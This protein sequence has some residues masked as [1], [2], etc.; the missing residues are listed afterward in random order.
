MKKSIEALF[1]FLMVILFAGALLPIIYVLF[2][3]VISLE[4]VSL[5]SQSISD[6]TRQLNLFRNTMVIAVGASL[7]SLILGAPL[8]FVLSRFSFAARSLFLLICPVPL[9]IPAYVH[10][11]CWM[12]LLGNHGFVSR[13]IQTAGISSADLYTPLGA[14]V[15]MALS[16]YPLVT[17]MSYVGFNQIDPDL[18]DAARLQTGA[19]K[20][21]WGITANIA[22]PAILTGALFSCIFALSNFGVPSMLRQQVYSQEVFYQFSN[23]HEM[24]KAALYSLPIL[25]LSLIAL[26]GIRRLEKGHRF[27]ISTATR[28]GNRLP[29]RRGSLLVIGLL[30]LLHLLSVGL[31]ISVLFE[32]AG[33]WDNYVA[34]L[35]NA[36]HDILLSFWSSVVSATLILATGGILALM[37][38]NG[39]R[40]AK[41]WLERACV[42][43]F[44]FPAAAAGIG[45]IGIWNRGGPFQWVYSSLFILLIAFFCRYVSFA[46]KPV[47]TAANYIDPSLDESA[48]LTGVS[49]RR[50]LLRVLAP[51]GGK[52]LIVAWFLVYL[53]SMI[54]LDT[55]ILVHPPGQA[56]L[57]VRI[58][59]LL[60]FGRQEWV[61]A[62]C[63]VLTGLT[64]IPYMIIM[65]WGSKKKNAISGM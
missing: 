56:T 32:M 2:R 65:L 49:W 46:F 42:L 29:L 13:L 12:H 25:L 50:R 9:L 41:G 33:D 35:S 39:P 31:P 58:F 36:R 44:A 11:I 15:I 55:V 7:L 40:R 14:I 54:D 59:N 16:Y 17:L 22:A 47:L 48:R 61:G 30:L 52:G 37:A 63:L 28:K 43:S 21:L 5:V 53:F 57:P 45:L 8:A 64:I 18:E 19:W 3:S 10:T 20:T 38:W 6:W 34:S 62:L 1:S 4:N 51:L 60:H 23:L 26:F 24:D 27:T